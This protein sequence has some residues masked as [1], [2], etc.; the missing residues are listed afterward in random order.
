MYCAYVLF[1]CSGTAMFFYRVYVMETPQPDS[2]FNLLNYMAF[3]VSISFS[4]NS[5]GSQN[6]LPY[7]ERIGRQPKKKGNI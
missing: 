4:L 5:N 1:M 3:Y 2:S 6:M 7:C